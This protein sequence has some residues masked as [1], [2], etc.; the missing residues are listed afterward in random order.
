MMLGRAAYGLLLQYVRQA[1]H[2][3]RA[4]KIAQPLI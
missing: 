3:G 4:E 1:Y 2:R